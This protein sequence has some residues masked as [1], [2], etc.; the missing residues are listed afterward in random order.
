MDRK[1]YYW[2]VGIP[3][4]FGLY[5]QVITQSSKVPQPT[6]LKAKWIEL[7]RTSDDS[8]R[9]HIIIPENTKPYY[10]RRILSPIF[11]GK[12]GNPVNIMHCIGY[13]DDTYQTMWGLNST[14]K[15]IH[16]FKERYAKKR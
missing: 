3:R 15:E 6:E 11:G 7:I 2:R 10:F 16:K 12:G 5:T 9:A 14:T 13:R 1:D 8:E 4:I